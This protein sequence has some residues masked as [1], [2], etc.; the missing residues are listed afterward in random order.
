[1]PFFQNIALDLYFSH[2]ATHTLRQ[3]LNLNQTLLP[4][5]LFGALSASGAGLPPELD[6]HR[7]SLCAQLFEKKKVS[8][9]KTMSNLLTN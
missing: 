2:S 1:M 6:V 9:A 5:L 4:L 3:T 8:P 7:R